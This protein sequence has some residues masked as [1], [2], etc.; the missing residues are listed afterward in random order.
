MRGRIR[1]IER[2]LSETGER[3][4]GEI[5]DR[6]RAL[7]APASIA[8]QPG[9]APAK[10]RETVAGFS[11]IL[12]RLRRQKE[13][14]ARERDRFEVEVQKKIAIPF[15]CAIFVLIGG[16][17]GIRVGSGGI[18][19]GVGLSL[20][21]FLLYYLFLV[22]GENLADRGLL[23]PIVAMWIADVVFAGV[24]IWLVADLARVGAARRA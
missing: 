4:R 10:P 13:I 3:S 6:A 7:F 16:P 14:K 24:G 1:T 18:G 5:V 23:S 20:G 9:V 19:V 12:D 17:L 22:G 11:E 15:A 21:F 2:E 8:P